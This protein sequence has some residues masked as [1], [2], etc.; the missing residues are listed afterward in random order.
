MVKRSLIA[1]VLVW[2]VL[3]L[4]PPFAPQTQRMRVPLNESGLWPY[5][6]L[7]SGQEL[8]QLTREYPDNGTLALAQFRSQNQTIDADYWRQLD[9]LVARYPDNL[10]LRRAKLVSANNLQL[11]TQIYAPQRLRD[12]RFKGIRESYKPQQRA[13]V[14]EQAR[15]GARQAPND[16]FFPWMEAIALWDRDDE[17]ALQALE[18]AA[19]TGDFDDGIMANQRALLSWQQKQKQYPL[20][21]DEKLGTVYGALFPHYAQIKVLQ[22]EVIWSGIEHYRRGDKAGAYRRWRIALEVAGALRRSHSHGPQAILLGIII[23]ESMQKEVW[24]TVAKELNLPTNF[25][26]KKA[27]ENWQLSAFQALARRDAQGALAQY[28]AREHAD[29]QVKKINAP[30]V[31]DNYDAALGLSA[32][33]TR[34]SLQTP[35]IGRNVF[36]LSV[37]GSLCSLIFLAWR[38]LS[39]RIGGEVSA[40][41]IAFFGALWTG[42]LALAAWGRVGP[43]MKTLSSLSSA[44]G[45]EAVP[46][47]WLIDFFDDAPLFWMAVTATLLSSIALCYWQKA[48]EDRRLQQ[49][50]LREG[51]P[52]PRSFAWWPVAVV[53]LWLLSFAAV[54]PLLSDGNNDN[55]ELLSL[56]WFALT[57]LALALTIVQVERSSTLDKSRRRLAILSAICAL[58]PFGLGAFFDFGQSVPLFFAAAFLMLG[59]LGILIYL[60]LTAT[61]W[62][63]LFAHALA[64][65]LQTMGGVAVVCSVAFLLAS[66]AALPV[67]AR[68]NRVVDDYIARGEVDWMR[69][70]PEIINASAKNVP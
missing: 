33:S 63:P 60:G 34:L 16:G 10:A 49:Q 69:S 1:L 25:D 55:R 27:P 50:I 29:S 41:Q 9:A 39:E 2:S 7:F 48:R 40:A 61:G 51:K 66:L 14:I 67:R 22:N 6:P 57:A 64:V 5:P 42:A 52:V 36:W 8:K 45:V 24:N 28:A 19:R 11:T 26:K 17:A 59:A 31:M 15:V 21:W 18:R 4:A 70:Q 43:E 12:S 44:G 46:W 68:Q 30:G 38:R 56:I 35:W 20:Q 47:N 54:T 13:I 23:G 3:L 65:A 32:T 37:V 62:R 53:L 58:I